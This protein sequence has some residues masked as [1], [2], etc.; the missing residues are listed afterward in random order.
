M[1]VFRS[2]GRL[3]A[4]ATIACTVVML[5]TVALAAASHSPMTDVPIVQSMPRCTMPGLDI[6]LDTNGS[7]T[8]GGSYYY[9]EF[10][11][12][13]GHACSLVGYP[14]V[15]A[16]NFANAWLG[17]AA[18]RNVAGAPKVVSLSDGTKATGLPPIGAKA[19]ATSVLKITDVGV[20]SASACHH[21]TAVALEVATGNHIAPKIIPFPFVACARNGP[22]YLHVGAWEKGILP[23]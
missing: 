16:I 3:V 23:A 8:A 5:P 14:W 6:W 1:H 2:S 20:F 13:S 10:T 9:L 11:N 15:R 19:T 21:L 22:V 18:S 7:G 17:S 4:L 12:L